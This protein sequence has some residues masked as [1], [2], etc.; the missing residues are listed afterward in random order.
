MEIIGVIRM[1]SVSSI[2]IWRT[3]INNC[4][5]SDCCIAAAVNID[6]FAVVNIDI[7]VFAASVNIIAA[8]AAV[9]IAVLPAIIKI[10][11]VF[12]SAVWVV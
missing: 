9:F 2:N 5:S 10:F 8:Y 12:G 7:G 1:V 11:V 6:V 3:G 4:V